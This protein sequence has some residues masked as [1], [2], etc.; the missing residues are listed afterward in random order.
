MN[1]KTALLAAPAIALAMSGA[2]FAAPVQHVSSHATV[3]QNTR[4]KP[5]NANGETGRYAGQMTRL[6][7]MIVDYLSYVTRSGT[8]GPLLT[9][10]NGG[11]SYGGGA[12]A[13]AGANAGTNGGG[14]SAG[15]NGGSNGGN[16]SNSNI[17]GTNGG[18]TGSANNG[19]NGGRGNGGVLRPLGFVAN[20]QV[21]VIDLPAQHSGLVNV[22]AKNMG[23]EI[24]L[25]GHVFNRGGAKVFVVDAVE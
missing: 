12:N 22:L 19:G 5:V 8:R 6:N 21:Y 13:G 20:G 25:M 11:G 14:A 3:A 15:A 10:M 17:V 24:A 2:A 16:G 18:G 7:G 4:N 23:R 1:Y 9:G